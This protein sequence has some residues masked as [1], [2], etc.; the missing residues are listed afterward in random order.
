MKFLMANKFGIMQGRL[1]P[2]HNNRYQA[3]PLG[4]WQGEFILAKELGLD[5]IEFIFDYNDYKLN[6]LMSLSGI[7]NIQ[8]VISE[9]GV[10]VKTICADYYMEA[11]IH[12]ANISVSKK[13][14]E[15]LKELIKNSSLLGVTDIILPCVDHSR[16]IDSSDRE[17][18]ITH[19]KSLNDFLND[20]KINISLETDL[21]PSDFFELIKAVNS[22]FI[23]INY[24]TGNSASFGYNLSEEFNAYGKYISDIHI[25][26]RLLNGG[27]VFFGEGNADFDLFFV[28]LKKL[29]YCGPI[30]FQLYRDDEGVEIFKKQFELFQSKYF[31]E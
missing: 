8:K 20:Y 15:V 19:L 3:H 31:Y 25:K 5:L 4:Y 29:N 11:P 30:I 24:D 26:D 18:L 22:P 16:L 6:P 27:S 23:K 1:M 14:L 21:N 10:N 12:S 17:R 13:S 9:T 2:K 28:E 7:K